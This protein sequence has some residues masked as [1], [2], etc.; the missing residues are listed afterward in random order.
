MSDH[1][2][3]QA[4][5]TGSSQDLSQVIPQDLSRDLSQAQSQDRPHVVIVGGGFGGLTAAKAL[6]RARV[7]LVDRRNHHLFQPLLYQVAMAGLSATDIAAPIRA[8]LRRQRDTTVLLGEVVGVELDTRT[9]Q[10]DGGRLTYDYLIL[11]AG[12]QTDYFNHP[13]WARFAAGLKTAEDAVEL[14]RRVLTAF[15]AAERSP[16]PEQR[17]QLLT[18]VIVGGGPTG[19]EL[20]GALAELSRHVLARDFRHINPRDAAI[21]LIEGGPRVLPSFPE[22][23]SERSRAKLTQLGVTVRTEQRVLDMDAHGVNLAQ[24][25]INAKTVI[26]A[27]GV[28]AVPLAQKL[29]VACDRG[30]RVL[31]EPDLTLPGH[32]EV[33]VIGDMAA[34][35]HQGGSPLPGL[36]P[37]AMQ[38]ARHVARNILA[39]Q[40]GE[41]HTPFHYVDKGNMAT[42]GRAAAVAVIGPFKFDGYLAW[43]LWLFVHVFFLITFAN[44]AAVLLTWAWQY[45]TYQRGARLITAAPPALA[46]PTEPPA[47]TPPTLFPAP[48]TKTAAA[49]RAS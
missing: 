49:G 6:R 47:L 25:R 21:I 43:L 1:S 18:F 41:P 46:P 37:V 27:A 36:S 24:E 38:Q 9:V 42:I 30:G 17:R 10:L 13:Q 26:W 15:E 8:V 39:A 44:R 3:S 29:G 7:T 28:R 32:K 23:L 11:A 4:P 48:V 16:D 34:F 22:F 19:V 20:A 35:L 2:F 40:R 14:R 12:A 33:F 5:S 45:L 31:V